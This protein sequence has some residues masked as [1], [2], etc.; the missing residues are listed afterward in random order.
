MHKEVSWVFLP[1][2]NLFVAILYFILGVIEV[3]K[4]ATFSF[5]FAA[6]LIWLAVSIMYISSHYRHKNAKSDNEELDN[7]E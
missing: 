1:I 6:G 5:W 3:S 7:K 4:G 2:I